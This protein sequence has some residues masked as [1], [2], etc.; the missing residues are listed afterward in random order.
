MLGIKLAPANE[1]AGAGDKGVAIVGV[2]PDGAAAEQ[3][4]ATGQVILDVGGK[5]VST[6]AGGE[7]RGREREE[8]GQEVGADADS[9]RRGRPLR[10][11]PLPQGV[12]AIPR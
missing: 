1:V 10:G 7:G 9:D 5:P 4:L 3:G 6:P 11:R 8:P 12:I 2:D